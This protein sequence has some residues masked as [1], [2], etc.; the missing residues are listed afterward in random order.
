M[1]ASHYYRIL[2]V[3]EN[4]DISEIK[5][6]F[7]RKAKSYHPDINK[8]EGAHQRFIDINEAYTYLMDLHGSSSGGSHGTVAGN[9]ARDEYY[10]RWV[11]RERQKA[12]RQAAQ[13]ARMKFEEFRKSS[14]YRTT[15]M[16]SHMLDYFL[17]FLGVFVIIAAGFGLYTQGLFIED[18]GEETLNIGGIVADLLITIAGILFII[19]SWSNI[20]AHRANQKKSRNHE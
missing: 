8:S 5:H 14:V 7:R 12:R 10:R 9:A 17:L 11:Q 6:A 18:N 13:R 16:L 2:G 1:N 20:K 3:P 4:A 15:T 19:M